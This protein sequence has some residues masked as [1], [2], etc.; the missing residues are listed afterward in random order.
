MFFGV[1]R[2]RL[3]AYFFFFAPRL[4]GFVVGLVTRFPQFNDFCLTSG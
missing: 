1:F 2:L 3:S 4:V